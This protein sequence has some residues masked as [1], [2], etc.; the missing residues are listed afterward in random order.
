[1]NHITVQYQFEHREVSIIIIVAIILLCCKI[2]SETALLKIAFERPNYWICIEGLW[3][4]TAY[5]T[6][7][8]G[9]KQKNTVDSTKST[10]LFTS[11]SLRQIIQILIQLVGWLVCATAKARTQ[12]PYSR[13]HHNDMCELQMP[14]ASNWMI[15][16]AINA[17]LLVRT[18]GWRVQQMS[19]GEA[20]IFFSLCNAVAVPIWSIW[21]HPQ[22]HTYFA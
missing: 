3:I 22:N 1:M 20:L 5:F 11:H 6:L 9:H 16:S 4:M 19:N 10:D 21:M 15:Y 2:A 8:N 12:K 17:L 13:T 7:W 14:S 18:C